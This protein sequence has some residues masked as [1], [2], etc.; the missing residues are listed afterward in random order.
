MMGSISIFLVG[1]LAQTFFITVA[2]KLETDPIIYYQ[3]PLHFDF[4]MKIGFHISDSG[5]NLLEY[6]YI[7]FLVNR[8]SLPFNSCF[9]YQG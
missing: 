3:I 2:L 1:T 4:T 7:Y 5:I 9:V 6:K 8:S